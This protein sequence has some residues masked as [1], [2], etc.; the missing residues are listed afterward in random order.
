VLDRVD[1]ESHKIAAVVIRPDFQH[2]AAEFRDSVLL[3][4]SPLRLALFAPARRE[5][6]DHAFDGVVIFPESEFSQPRRV[7]NRHLADVANSHGH[8]VVVPT[9]TLPMSRS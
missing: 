6:Q 7:S 5:A 2:R 8:A 1:R 9:T 3:F 4:F